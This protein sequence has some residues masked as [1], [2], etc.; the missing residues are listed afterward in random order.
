MLSLYDETDKRRSY[1]VAKLPLGIT[2]GQWNL[3]VGDLKDNPSTI[4]DYRKVLNLLHSFENQRFHISTM[5]KEDAQYYFSCLDQ[6]VEN[7]TL[8]K[9][10]AHRY[11]ATLRSLGAKLQNSDIFPGY[12][13]PFSQLVKN[14]LRK[15]T[16][17]TTDIF[18]SREVIQK[19]HSYLPQLPNDESLILQLMIYLG[20]SPNQIENIRVCDF[21]KTANGTLT[22]TIPLGTF[23]DR[24]GVD[25]EESFYRV[26][27]YPVRFIRRNESKVTTWEYLGTFEF[28][29]E[30]ADLIRYHSPTIGENDD[31]RPFF[32]TSRH[33]PYNYRAIHHL[34]VT[35][36]QKAGIENNV[37]TPYKLSLHGMIHSYLLDQ[38]LRKHAELD[39][40]LRKKDL[41]P[42]DAQA[43]RQEVR[44]V[45]KVF[46]PLA[47][48]GW[49]GN[50]QDR[51]PLP[52]LKQIDAITAQLGPGVLKQIT[53]ID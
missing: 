15:P 35:T 30:F 24:S 46:I 23:Q 16:T 9:N 49:I 7:G 52:Y 31:D 53:G 37:V 45:E 26:N 28:F 14:E 13:N 4:N 10:T 1:M 43:L 32:M 22:L 44:E 39:K 38:N 18:L 29:D 11:K 8:S 51:Y 5:S 40:K 17:Y 2:A 48:R 25:P 34:V 50:W 3:I 33:L 36:A 41:D 42:Q 27:R 21:G 6:R 20:L 47:Q 12:T 19:L